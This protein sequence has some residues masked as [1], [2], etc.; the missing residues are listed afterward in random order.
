MLGHRSAAA[1]A[2]TVIVTAAGAAGC[3]GSSTPTAGAAQSPAVGAAVT[4]TATPDP[5]A[6]GL[7][8]PGVPDPCGLVAAADVLKAAHIPVN[9]KSGA[10]QAAGGGR[11]CAYNAGHPNAATI[12]LTA[13]S[14][15]GFDAFRQL[16]AGGLTDLPG[17]GQEAYRT[18]QTPGVV[19][20]YKNGFD[21]NIDVINADSSSQATADAKALA[22]LVAPKL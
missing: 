14:K 20:V 15:A 22:V 8:V 21:I 9:A 10:V 18:S 1:V 13:V 5:A 19:D 7:A 16:A 17:I 6:V 3:G 4:A 12:S 2:I 11:S